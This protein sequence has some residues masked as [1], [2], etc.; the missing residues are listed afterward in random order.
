MKRLILA[1]IILSILITYT[2][3][4]ERFVNNFCSQATAVLEECAL[5]I[6]EE[7]YSHAESNASKL[8][9]MWEENDILMSVLIGDD[10]VV[11]PQ[12]SIVAILMSL[13][14]EN[15]DECLVTIR[16]CQGYLHEITENNR[17][18]LGNVL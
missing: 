18:T 12:K 17:T 9:D 8:Y 2:F 11:E 4:S 13:K 6:T 5:N 15:Y 14:D 16:E 10:S 1:F 7:K 3:F